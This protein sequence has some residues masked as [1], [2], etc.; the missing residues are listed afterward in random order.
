VVIV[1]QQIDSALA[2][3]D[4]AV[5]MERGEIRLSGTADELRRDERVRAIYLGLQ[6][7]DE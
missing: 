2:V 6:D 1:E 3:A 4:R 7:A 5:I